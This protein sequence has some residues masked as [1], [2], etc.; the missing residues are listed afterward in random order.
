MWPSPG[1]PWLTPRPRRAG[2]G[3]GVRKVQSTG[4]APHRMAQKHV[5]LFENWVGLRFLHSLNNF[6]IG[7]REKDETKEKSPRIPP[8]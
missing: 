5:P 1:N 8:G 6:I 7:N 3:V 2:S 4:F